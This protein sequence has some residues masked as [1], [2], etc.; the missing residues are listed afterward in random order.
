MYNHIS[1]LY[2]SV[3][4]RFESSKEQ[5]KELGYLKENLTY[6]GLEQIQKLERN[7]PLVRKEEGQIQE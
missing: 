7:E 6:N 5:L 4:K 2:E 1:C 3:L